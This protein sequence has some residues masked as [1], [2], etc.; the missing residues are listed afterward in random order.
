L[1]AAHPHVA[2]EL[3][4]LVERSLPREEFERRVRAPLSEDELEE[5]AALVRWFTDRYPTVGERFAYVRRAWRRWT[6]P[7][8][9]EAP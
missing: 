8:R 5:T 2:P 4:E 3:A 9:I 7:A 1:N 6:R